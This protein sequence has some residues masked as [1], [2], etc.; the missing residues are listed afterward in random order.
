MID[1][2][3]VSHLLLWI[4]VLV[5]AT[6]VVV[7]VRQVGLLHERI[8]PTGAL[9]LSKGPAV[10]EKAPQVDMVALDGTLHRV[11]EATG[12]RR[13]TLLFFLSPTCPVCKTLLP[14]LARLVRERGT[15]LVLA[16]DGEELDHAGFAN[17][18]GLDP[19]AYFVSNELGLR[20][21]IAKL[22]Y[23]VLIDPDGVVRGQGIVNTR[24]HL[25]SLFEAEELGVASIQE[26][27]E[28]RLPVVSDEG[29]QA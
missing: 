10:G 2:L 8:A 24:E 4:L 29:A 13:S 5:L 15:Q 18:H 22:P 1:A 3:L 28:R 20:Y 21:Q 9:A 11:G 19:A 6:A 16:S 23:G 7:L 12:D 26:Y 14:T 25:E 27:L 17:T